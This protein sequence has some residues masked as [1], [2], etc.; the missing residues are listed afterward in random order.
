VRLPE[1]RTL[2]AQA[3]ELT[4]KDPFIM[5]SMGWVE[6]RL[7]KFKEAE[8]LLRQAYALR[9]DVEIATHLGEVLWV[10]GK[11]SEAQQLLRA[12]LAKEPDNDSLKNTLIRLKIKL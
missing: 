8:T 1:A 5:D 2:I 11:K 12:A 3:L 7:G 9:P 10:R 6:F 4:P